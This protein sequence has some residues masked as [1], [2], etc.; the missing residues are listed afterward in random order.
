MPG[1]PRWAARAFT[2][3]MTGAL[4]GGLTS[5]AA[6][7]PTPSSEARMAAGPGAAILAPAE[8]AATPPLGQLRREEADLAEQLARR[9]VPTAA[10]RSGP[11]RGSFVRPARGAVTSVFGE[12]RGTARHPGMDF[13]G[14][15]GDRV[16]AAGAGTA[17]LAGP[18]PA[19]YSGYG[20]LVVLDHGGGVQTVYAHLSQT[21]IRPGMAVLA[22]EH[23]GAIGTTGVVT[24]SHLHFEVRQGGVA[25]NPRHWLPGG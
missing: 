9:G 12:R 22:G 18:A 20:I 25:V 11:E 10:S 6:L 21:V 8:P 16:V 2:T 5:H 24:G 7:A 4:A 13:D 19:G 23:I 1:N 17:A 15:T 3:V 14:N